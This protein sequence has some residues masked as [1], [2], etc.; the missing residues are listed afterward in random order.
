MTALRIDLCPI[1][2]SIAADRGWPPAVA[3]EFSEHAETCLD[4]HAQK[5]AVFEALG[6][7]E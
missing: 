3:R 2:E 5:T 1:G 4:C 7:S 6:A